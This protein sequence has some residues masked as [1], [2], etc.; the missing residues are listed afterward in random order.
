MTTLTFNTDFS[1]DTFANKD[2]LSVFKQKTEKHISIQQGMSV[3]EISDIVS[4]KIISIIREQF[5]DTEEKFVKKNK[6]GKP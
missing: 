2:V 5:K 1:I 3:N 6:K 4:D